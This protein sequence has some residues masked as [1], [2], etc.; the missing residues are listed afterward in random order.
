MSF[1][2]SLWPDLC[3]G[4]IQQEVCTLSWITAMMEMQ[5][6]KAVELEWKG[7]GQGHRNEEKNPW[8]VALWY[9]TYHWLRPELAPKQEI[10][11]SIRSTE[12][13]LASSRWTPC[14]SASIESCTIISAISKLKISGLPWPWK[15][16][17]RT[18]NLSLGWIS[19]WYFGKS[20]ATQHRRPW[21]T[22]KAAAPASQDDLSR[23]RD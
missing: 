4:T 23:Y 21:A 8:R 3:K 17:W 16:Y 15:V 1:K 9:I 7:W 18:S 19:M 5:V 11:M 2:Y 12:G 22:A 6:H 10:H 20:W 14:H 13:T